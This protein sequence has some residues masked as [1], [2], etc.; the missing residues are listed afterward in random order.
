MPAPLL[1]KTAVAAAMVGTLAAAGTPPAAA[2]VVNLSWSGAFTWLN[3]TGGT[4]GNGFSDYGA[5]FYANGDSSNYTFGAPYFPGNVGSGATPSSFYPGAIYTAHAWY[6]NRTPLS[7][8]I[9]FDLSTGAGVGTINPFFFFGDIPG[10]GPGTNIADFQNLTFQRVDTAGTLVGTM[11]LSWNG[12][13][14]SISIVLDASGLFA[15]LNAMI[16]GGPTSTISGVGAL[17]ATDGLNFQSGP[18]VTTYP[19]GPSP[20]ASKTL[21]A[22]G[23]EAQPLA[24]Q[25]NAWTINPTGNIANCDLTQDDG[26]GGSP[27]VSAA[28]ANLNF[29]FDATSV[30]FDGLSQVPVP[31]GVW[32]FGSGLLG[33]IGLARR[34]REG[35]A[36]RRT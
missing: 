16:A 11:L 14:H 10:S 29:I 28:F 3:P 36:T 15:N 2:D 19:L 24:T 34:G 25:V 21:N 30:Q 6:G 9:S 23:C 4:L 20:I 33:L 12:A 22:L 5:G 35:K 8:T 31:A 18:S 1:S 17:P 32:L 13:G 27:A 7:G 26:I